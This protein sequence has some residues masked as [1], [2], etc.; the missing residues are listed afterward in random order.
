[1]PSLVTTCL[2]NRLR[3]GERCA[4]ASVWFGSDDAGRGVRSKDAPDARRRRAG[5]PIIA[6]IGILVDEWNPEPGEHDHRER[7]Q[8]GGE[9]FDHESGEQRGREH[10]DDEQLRLV[11]LLDEDHAQA[12][13]VDQRDAGRNQRR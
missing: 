3:P 4:R 6:K 10:G 8:Q 11:P 7:Q 12:G 9:A 2:A 1:M 13:D 5:P